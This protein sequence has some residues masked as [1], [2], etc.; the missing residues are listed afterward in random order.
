MSCNDGRFD[1]RGYLV[2]LIFGRRPQ[3]FE[4]PGVVE[5]KVWKFTNG[6]SVRDQ[7]LSEALDQ[8]DRLAVIRENLKGDDGGIYEER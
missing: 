8:V 4:I 6:V 2:R 5:P 3:V 7:S 1:T